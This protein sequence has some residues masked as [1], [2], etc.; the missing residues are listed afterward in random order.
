MTAAHHLAEWGLHVYLADREPHLGGAFL[1]LD[2]TFPTD[3]CGLCL[4]LPR[5]PSYCPTIASALDPRITP[6]PDT[7]LDSLAG[8]PGHFVAT[9]RQASRF[10]DPDL[11]DNCGACVA[12]CPVS[13]P[14]SRWG[15]FL[16][17]DPQKAI[18]PPPPRGEPFVYAIDAE[19]CTRCRACVDV[20]PRGAIDLHAPLTEH[21]IEVGAVVLAPGFAA[22]DASL[23]GEY[24]WGRCD[25]VVTS[26]E[27]ERM[28]N[29]SGPTGGR[30]LRPSDGQ[31]PRHIA[32]IH[33]VG[34]RSEKLGR[35]YCSSSCCMISA[36]QVGLVKEV[37][38]E[39]EV[40]AFTM[41]VRASGK[42]Y[43]RYIERAAAL[44]GVTY[45]QGLPAAVLASPNGQGLRL[46]TPD[47]EEPFDMVVLAVGMGPVEGARELAARAGVTLDESGFIRPGEDGPGSTSRPG[48]Y[49]AGSAL[50]PA[51]VPKTVTQAAAAAALVGRTCCPTGRLAKPPYREKAFGMGLADQ[52]PRIGLFLCTC[53][54]TLEGPLDFSTLA[55]EGER[56]R[57]VVH[58]ERVEEICEES[59]Q[60]AIEHAVMEHGLNRIVIAGCSARLYGGQFDA[61]M[62]RLGLPS[63]LLARADIR[64]GGAWVHAVDPAAAA[65]VARSALAV[66]V[67]GLRET[68]Y[69]PFDV[70][71]QEDA[72][73]R[74]L[75]LGG[76]L[77]GMTAVLT[78]DALGVPCDLVE[79]EAQLGGNLRELQRT[80]EGLD[81]QALLAETV[82]RVRRAGRVR[83]W[84]GAE[85]ARWSGVRGDFAAEIRV[86]GETR[87]DRYGALILATGARQVEPHEYLYGQHS[88]IITQRK[89]ESLIAN[90]KR[91]TA[92]TVVMIQ[93]VGSRDDAHPYCSRVCCAQAVKN[94]LALKATDPDVEVGIV[95]RDVRTMG[96][97]ELYYER[98]RQQGVMF[99]QYD[100]ERKPRV[101]SRDS[102]LEVSVW[103]SVLNDDIVLPA[104]LVVLGAGIEPDVGGAD[105]ARLLDVA[106]DEDG[107]FAEAHPK[108]RPTDLA[109]PG[110]FLCGLAYGPGFVIESIAQAR[111]AALRAALAVARPPRPRRDVASVVQKLCSYCGLCVA[112]CPY[113][114]R[115]LDEEERYANGRHARV[116]DH[117]CQGCG[118]CVAVCP[119]GASRQ[120]ALE[121][122]QM[123]A[124]VDAALY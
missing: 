106:L 88:S 10:V 40:T 66:A 8:E 109:R 3:S 5:Q 26:L 35:P 50:A 49:A 31:P 22:F 82:T 110:V 103:D 117:L 13:R 113:G 16:F 78:L 100:L 62:A 104:D 102:G 33:C 112:H 73:G 95:F 27:L 6:L 61:L 107:F 44:P 120:P 54:G 36:K 123:L 24:G 11:C 38:P 81:V 121:P 17:E 4:A 84:S 21:R 69:Q 101:E 70:R 72:A 58:V 55:V 96:T 124:W 116:L 67:A 115:V 12:V 18:Y 45:R 1:L 99:L 87:T 15:R 42:G 56:M 86:G 76:G 48:V 98:A 118:V 90:G 43:E 94:A 34:S 105:L 74:V 85:L 39:T 63:R 57:G 32:F 29:R 20:C 111:A 114:A 2:H 119:N 60:A 68:P 92:N 25:N 23:A 122:V 93:C 79:R 80:L 97:H 30:L 65:A 52:P 64:E 71:P 51:D 9:L 47:G 59:G 53:R 46:L 28:L 37:A 91:P 83:V 41:D 108:L 89:L 77:S 75:V 14:R 19:V 7:V